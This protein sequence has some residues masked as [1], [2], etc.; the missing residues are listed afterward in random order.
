MFC[1]PTNNSTVALT[2][3]QREINDAC[4]TFDITPE[5][6]Y[7]EFEFSAIYMHWTATPDEV[8]T[9]MA[10]NQQCVDVDIKGQW[11]DIQQLE[12]ASLPTRL[13]ACRYI[14]AA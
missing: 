12:E 2:L 5:D 1:C 14:I 7:L 10:R 3:D 13:M 6:Y 9:M 11:V 8:K 4:R